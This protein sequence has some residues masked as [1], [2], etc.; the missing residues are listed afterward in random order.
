[1][2]GSKPV[3]FT[4]DRAPFKGVGVVDVGRTLPKDAS[5]GLRGQFLS[6]FIAQKV[7]IND[8]GGDVPT[9]VMYEGFWQSVGISMTA[10]GE[11]EAWHWGDVNLALRELQGYLEDTDNA[12]RPLQVL[13]SMPTVQQLSLSI[14]V[15]ETKDFIQ[16]ISGQNLKNA[17]LLGSVYPRSK[18]GSRAC[19]SLLDNSMQWIQSRADCASF[20]PGDFDIF[21]GIGGLDPAALTVRIGLDTNDDDFY[22]TTG[23]YKDFLQGLSRYIKEVRGGEC[24][25][26]KVFLVRD[27]KICGSMEIAKGLY[28]GRSHN[29]HDSSVG[30]TLSS[31]GCASDGKSVEPVVTEQI[32]AAS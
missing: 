21:N 25:G 13:I 11:G 17:H 32:V 7:D 22:L 3:Q 28:Q 9:D 30:P 15:P 16:P 12:E 24:L 1:M 26:L 8:R 23:E 29:F 19:K 6:A 27:R 4:F 2:F 5:Y 18:L 20:I 10:F 14:L 31:N